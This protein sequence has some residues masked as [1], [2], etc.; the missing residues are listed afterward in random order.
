MTPPPS[1]LK[2]LYIDGNPKLSHIP[3]SLLFVPELG[4]FD[5]GEIEHTKEELVDEASAM[6]SSEFQIPPLMELVAR[7][8]HSCLEGMQLN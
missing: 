6:N 1:S 3:I 2:K 4:V 5:C 7:S 8:L